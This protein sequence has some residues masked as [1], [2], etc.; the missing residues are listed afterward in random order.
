MKVSSSDDVGEKDTV[1]TIVADSHYEYTIEIKQGAKSYAGKGRCWVVFAESEDEG[2]SEGESEV[3]SESE[4]ESEDEDEEARKHAESF[5]PDHWF[6]VGQLEI[7][8]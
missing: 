2:E 4:S 7:E 8:L 1:P 3:E 6:M 5:L